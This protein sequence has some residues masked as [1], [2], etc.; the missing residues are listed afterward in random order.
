MFEWTGA[1]WT[2]VTTIIAPDASQNDRF[3][4]TVAIDGDRIAVGTPRHTNPS[5]PNSVQEGAIITWERESGVWVPGSLV[6]SLNSRSIDHMGTSV[7]I[8]GNL[9][10]AGA[11]APEVYF[12]YPGQAHVF[13]RQ[14]KVSWP[15]IAT[16]AASDMGSLD[17]F[18]TSVAI[19]G[20]GIVRWSAESARSPGRFFIGVQFEKLSATEK[21]KIAAMRT[22]F[23]SREYK[24]KSAARKRM[25][26]PQIQTDM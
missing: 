5:I 15:E 18:G 14:S 11:P 17:Y 23:T 9:M 1:Q 26:G 25:K 21:S 20:N 3:G 10:V 2:H 22:W 4:Q 13:Q 6:K 24:I 12:S 19:D 8:Q 16:L 7:A